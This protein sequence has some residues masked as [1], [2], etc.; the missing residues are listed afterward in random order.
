MSQLPENFSAPIGTPFR[1]RFS[2]ATP[3]NFWG[4]LTDEKSSC[5]VPILLLSF[6]RGVLEGYR[7]GLLTKNDCGI[8]TSMMNTWLAFGMVPECIYVPIE[9]S[10]INGKIGPIAKPY[11]QLRQKNEIGTV[12]GRVEF[13]LADCI[14]FSEILNTP[15]I[16]SS[17]AIDAISIKVNIQTESIP[18]EII[19][20]MESFESDLPQAPPPTQEDN[21]WDSPLD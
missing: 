3:K 17:A 4:F 18:E 7:S 5:F 6:H 21:P 2:T 16:F 8:Y 13:S 20:M 19:K 14:I 11:I 12:L 9:V 1:L 15:I 10:K